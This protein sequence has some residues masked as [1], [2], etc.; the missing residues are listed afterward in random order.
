MNRAQRRDAARRGRRLA[1]M[2][3]ASALVAGGVSIVSGSLLSAAG[4][5]D[6]VVTNLNGDGAGSL[7]DAINL[8]NDG[9]V[10]TFQ[11][12]LSGTI[13]MTKDNPRI[14]DDITIQGPGSGV[15]TIDG[16]DKYHP[17]QFEHDGAAA[18]SGLTITRGYTDNNLGSPQ[19]SDSSGGGIALYENGGDLTVSDMVITDNRSY[20]DGGGI[21]CSDA[22][23][24]QIQNTT[25]SN[26]VAYAGG[27]IYSDGC[28]I[29]VV[30]STIANNVTTDGGGG[31]GFYLSDTNF[32]MRG[33]TVSGN[34][35]DGW[36]GGFYVDNGA[37][38]SF[39]ITN[40][41]ISGNTAG[42]DGGGIYFNSAGGTIIQSTITDNTADDTGGIATEDAG[43]TAVKGTQKAATAKRGEDQAKKAEKAAAA[44]NVGAQQTTYDVHLV[45]TIVAGNSGNDVF[46]QGEEDGEINS[47]NSLIGT[48]GPDTIVHDQGGTLL[49]VD[50]L[51]GPLA[52]NGGPTMTHALLAGSPAINAGPQPLPDFEGN[53]FDQRGAGFVRV[54]DGRVD[55]G[56]F[57]TQPVVVRF[58]G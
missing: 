31:G 58:T 25:I 13:V 1:A 40:S 43:A 29:T 39:L 3:S 52:D 10:I 11:A 20:N 4:A 16:Q 26:N 5:A 23:H 55:I 12:G 42:D 24:L 53:E 28:D 22:G 2:G 30:S 57:E 34:T 37:E 38:Y 9:D 15:I 6:A 33:S 50:P 32:E 8:A 45:G 19:N 17:F 7:Y 54:I 21:W 44:A 48:V 27:G 35:A 36:G 51:L 18:I 56:A 46:G 47:L 49:G 41:T 14:F